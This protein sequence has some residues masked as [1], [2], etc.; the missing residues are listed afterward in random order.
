MP[1][2]IIYSTFERFIILIIYE[3]VFLGFVF[4]IC[5]DNERRYRKEWEGAC[6]KARDETDS[7]A[8]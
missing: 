8:T 3:C 2:I 5:E 4:F 7:I 1:I 6:N